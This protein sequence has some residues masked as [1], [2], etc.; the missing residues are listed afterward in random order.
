MFIELKI[1]T[2]KSYFYSLSNLLGSTIGFSDLNKVIGLRFLLKLIFTIALSTIVIK[3]TIL[4]D[5]TSHFAFK[6][7][8]ANFLIIFLLSN[9]KKVFSLRSNIK[10]KLKLIHAPSFIQVLKPD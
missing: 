6:M 2:F 7:V 5:E 1:S 8:A 9:V 10:E 4:N 3:I